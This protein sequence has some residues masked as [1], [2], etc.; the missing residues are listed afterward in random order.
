VFLADKFLERLRPHP[1][2]E[3]R[4]AVCCF[5]LFLFLE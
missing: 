1:R 3:R 2:G 5:N 4:S